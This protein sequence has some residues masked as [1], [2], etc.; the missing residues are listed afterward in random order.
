MHNVRKIGTDLYWV[1]G[2]DRRLA[3]FENVFPVSRGI[4]YNA[5]LMLDENELMCRD[6]VAVPAAAGAEGRVHV[7][8]ERGAQS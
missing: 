5:Y 7:D 6:L 3:L 4:S 1:G 8:R 2:S